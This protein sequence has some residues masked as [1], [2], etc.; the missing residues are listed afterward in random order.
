MPARVPRA[1]AAIARALLV[2]GALLTAAAAAEPLEAA[3]GLFLHE[4]LARAQKGAWSEYSMAAPG[5]SGALKMRYSVVDRTAALL[6][7]EV[8]LETPRGPFLMRMDFVDDA[9]AGGWTVQHGRVQLADQPPMD[10]PPEEG[11]VIKKGAALGRL[12]GTEPVTTPAG[13]FRCRHFR[14]RTARGDVDV[15]YSLKASPTGVVKTVDAHGAQM[16]LVASGQG[17]TPRL[18]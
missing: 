15:W 1:P 5:R 18:K 12:I 9:H 7:V 2:G 13:R 16:V 6:G 11:A 3:T 10:M 4:A 14:Q 8:D 17:A